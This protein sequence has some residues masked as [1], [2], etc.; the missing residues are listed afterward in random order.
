M[1]REGRRSRCVKTNVSDWGI[2]K[3]TR[4]LKLVTLE[5]LDPRTKWDVY[6]P[7]YCGVNCR[8]GP[9]VNN[10]VSI[11]SIVALEFFNGI[12]NQAA[13]SCVGGSFYSRD[14]F[15][16][17]LRSFTNFAMTRS[18]EDSKSEIVAFFAHASHETG[19]KISLTLSI[20]LK[21]HM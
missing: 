21:I 7:D 15:L 9:C 10:G 3:G 8:G 14:A 4:G 11:A 2:F 19:C 16:G 6:S 18:V 5:G 12:L 20:M 17:A 1:V 13:A